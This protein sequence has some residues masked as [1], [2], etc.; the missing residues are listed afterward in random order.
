MAER[1]LANKCN[2]TRS[3]QTQAKNP[4][5][6]RAPA[7]AVGIPVSVAAGWA[8]TFASRAAVRRAQAVRRPTARLPNLAS[9]QT[10]GEA[11]R[12]MSESKMQGRVH[13]RAR[14]STKHVVFNKTHTYTPSYQIQT[15]QTYLRG[16]HR[17]CCVRD[18]ER[19]CSAACRAVAIRCRRH[20]APAA[21]AARRP[22][23]AT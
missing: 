7:I 8:A 10:E 4:S 5:A 23:Q 21:A 16:V 13:A 2:Q 14:A 11:E 15:I 17:Q 3:T 19:Q 18:T 12:S 6:S 9:G 20:G 1:G 22:E